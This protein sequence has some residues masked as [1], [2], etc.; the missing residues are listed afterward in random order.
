MAKLTV[1]DA[2][3][4]LGVSKEAIH[5]RIRRGSLKSVI[6]DGIK[7]VLLDVNTT[8]TNKTKVVNKKSNINTDDRYYQLLE[9]QNKNLQLR[10]DTLESETRSLRD[11]KEQMLI[12][13]RIKIEQIY[14]DKDE[15]LKNILN[16]ISS[17][18]MLNKPNDGQIDE[19]IIEDL[20]IEEDEPKDRL[21]SL[22]KHLKSLSFSKKKRQTIKDKFLKKSKKDSR[23]IIINKKLYLDLDKYDY[24]DLS[25]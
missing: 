18:F 11:Q 16:A 23:I 7:F 15:Q 4:K 19:D 20:T 10:V 9:E 21:I 24:S 14:K 6:E 2:A 8:T 12:D 25:L 17:K 1:T 13:E 5:N 22:N 3:D